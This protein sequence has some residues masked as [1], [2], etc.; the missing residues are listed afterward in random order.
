MLFSP[1]ID[2]R[3]NVLNKGLATIARGLVA[4]IYTP[5]LSWLS[6]CPKYLQPT[7]HKVSSHAWQ[8]KAKTMRK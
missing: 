3:E 6:Y 4:N 1:V 8:H 5:I 2:A 7:F